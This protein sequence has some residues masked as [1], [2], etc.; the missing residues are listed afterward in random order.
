MDTNETTLLSII[1]VQRQ[2][3]QFAPAFSYVN[4]LR[5]KY[6]PQHHIHIYHLS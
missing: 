1:Q 2:V 6:S 5:P 4:P 3:I